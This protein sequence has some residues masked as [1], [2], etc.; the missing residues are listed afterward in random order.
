MD[1]LLDKVRGYESDGGVP[2]CIRCAKRF[3]YVDSAVK[4]GELTPIY[5]N[6]PMLTGI[7]CGVPV[8]NEVIDLD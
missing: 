2:L 1:K 5:G 8:C 3:H 7:E 4:S 6:H